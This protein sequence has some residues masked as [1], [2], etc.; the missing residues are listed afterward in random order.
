MWRLTADVLTVLC[1]AGWALVVTLW[2]RSYHLADRIG[3]Y[4][5]LPGPSPGARL[6]IG[7]RAAWRRCTIRSHRGS[8]EADVTTTTVTGRSHVDLAAAKWHPRAP[9]NGWWFSPSHSGE[10][11]PPLARASVRTWAGVGAWLSEASDR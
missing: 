5:D 9:A 6:G 1:L 3:S 10:S 8:I 11:P 4:H 7:E 2:V